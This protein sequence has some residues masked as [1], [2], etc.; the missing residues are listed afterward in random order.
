MSTSQVE[1]ENKTLVGIRKSC[2]AAAAVMEAASK[3]VRVGLTTADVEAVVAKEI[4]RQGGRSAFLGYHGFPGALCISLND[5]VLHGIPSKS[6]K[7]A[8]GD[9]V[10]LDLG[11]VLDGYYSDMA[12]SFLMDDGSESSRKK[13]AL[14]DATL[15]ALMACVS[16]LIRSGMPVLMIS[17][18]IEGH[19]A[20]KGYK[21]I[22]DMTG[23]GVGLRL[24]ESPVVPN[25]VPPGIKDLSATNDML[26]AGMTIAVEPMACM[27]STKCRIKNDGWTIVMEDGLSAAHFEHTLLITD[28][29]QEILTRLS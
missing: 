5:E 17:A 27:G 8:N 14:M 16:P 4:A 13:R 15:S 20:S 28:G 9:L 19:L 25:A 12:A 3:A 22:D 1:T 23:H 21:P 7:L 18:C 2:K 26:V 24:H 11:V 29:A 10:K 6:R